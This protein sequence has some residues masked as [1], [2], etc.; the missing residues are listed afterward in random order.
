MQARG[1]CSSGWGMWRGQA[2]AAILA[3]CYSWCS[4]SWWTGNRVQS[5]PL[6]TPPSAGLPDGWTQPFWKPELVFKLLIG[7]H[8]PPVFLKILQNIFGF[9][10]V[11]V[12]QNQH[13]SDSYCFESS[14]QCG[15][16]DNLADAQE[17][18]M[19]LNILLPHFV[20]TK[21][22]QPKPYSSFSIVLHVSKLKAEA[23]PLLMQ[24]RRT[25]AKADSTGST[26]KLW[27]SSSGLCCL[28]CCQ[29][30]LLRSELSSGGGQNNKNNNYNNNNSNNYY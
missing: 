2:N 7:H 30:E 9:A 4:Q 16:Y 20:L 22:A 23:G 15:H 3:F 10:V 11:L 12:K 13:T 8:W 5:L 21:G 26:K 29:C 6:Q 19:L 1:C 18:H 27:C 28:L 14:L 17:L 24:W 25:V